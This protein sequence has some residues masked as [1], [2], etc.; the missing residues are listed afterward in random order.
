MTDGLV[1]KLVGAMSTG[2]P[3][4]SLTRS[5]TAADPVRPD[6]RPVRAAVL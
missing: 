5:I 6:A 1:T 3:T 4:S 2:A